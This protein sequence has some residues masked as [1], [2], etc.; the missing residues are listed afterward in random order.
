MGLEKCAVK[1]REPQWGRT[2]YMYEHAWKQLLW[3]QGRQWREAQGPLPAGEASTLPPAGCVGLCRT[4]PLRLSGGV[5]LMRGQE[6]LAGSGGALDHGKKIPFLWSERPLKY[7]LPEDTRKLGRAGLLQ[8]DNDPLL[9][10]FQGQEEVFRF[11]CG[12]LLPFRLS[13]MEYLE[14]N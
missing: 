7:H 4:L 6:A 14:I 3:G 2:R 5:S 8:K 13:L 1:G 12:L 11:L 9:T 10:T